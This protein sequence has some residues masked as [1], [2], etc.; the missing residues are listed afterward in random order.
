MDGSI[1]D[2]SGGVFNFEKGNA[3]ILRGWW[4]RS[5]EA[6]HEG[7]STIS[8]RADFGQRNAKKK[9]RIHAIH[10]IYTFHPQLF[11]SL[12]CSQSERRLETS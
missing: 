5:S 10:R 4:L 7:A 11:H 6:T 1:H 8:E 3:T 9:L 12:T 2:R